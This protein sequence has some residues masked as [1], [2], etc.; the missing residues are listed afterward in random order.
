MRGTEG[1]SLPP[2]VADFAAKAAGIIVKRILGK[3]FDIFAFI[4]SYHL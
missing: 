2:K 4:G 1:V 3:I